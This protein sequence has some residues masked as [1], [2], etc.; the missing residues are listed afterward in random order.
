M[1]KIKDSGMKPEE[2]ILLKRISNLG[3]DKK[4]EKLEALITSGYSA[5][6]SK[7]FLSDYKGYKFN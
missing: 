7:S 1:A 3:G 2:Y 6:E 4:D 5:K